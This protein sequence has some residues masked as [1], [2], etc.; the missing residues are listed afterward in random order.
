MLH[1]PLVRS[2]DT[3]TTQQ[4]AAVVIFACLSFSLNFR[5]Q[6]QSEDKEELTALLLHSLLSLIYIVCLCSFLQQQRPRQQHIYSRSSLRVQEPT[7]AVSQH[8]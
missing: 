3:F 4:Y 2:L 5:V 8:P 1:T 7:L 6:Q